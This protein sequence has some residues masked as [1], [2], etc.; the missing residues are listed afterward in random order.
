MTRAPTSPPSPLGERPMVEEARTHA[1]GHCCPSRMALR[2]W[3]DGG[4]TGRR[5][6]GCHTPPVN[7]I[8][9]GG[10]HEGA[11]A[12]SQGPRSRADALAQ[13]EALA[14]LRAPGD[15]ID[16][17]YASPPPL[18]LTDGDRTGV[19]R[20]RA[21]DTP[22]TDAAGHSRMSVADYAAAIVDVLEN[23]AFTKRRFAV[24]Y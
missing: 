8:A 20:L 7:T 16:W 18:Y 24:A 14:R 19:Y 17:S 9:G 21:G 15:A 6:P 2:G 13:A 23:G 12:R 1:F 4:S 10:G 22:V 11:A 5:G 3:S